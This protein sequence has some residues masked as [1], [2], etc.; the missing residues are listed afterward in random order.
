MSSRASTARLIRKATVLGAIYFATAWLGLRFSPV[1]GFATLIWPPTGIALAAL[2]LYGPRLWPGIFLAATAVNFLTGAPLHVAVAIGVG[3]TLGPLA[4]ARMLV[5]ARF[6]PALDRLKDIFALTVFAASVSTAISATIGTLSLTAGGIAGFEA[7]VS[8]WRAW[9]IGDML[10]VLIFAPLILTWLKPTSEPGFRFVRLLERIALLAIF[11]TSSWLVFGGV[12]ADPAAA[13]S[14][15][16][17]FAP[18]VIWAALRFSPRETATGVFIISVVAIWGTVTGH[19]PFVR[20]SIS[21]SLF[22]LQVFMGV[23]AVSGMVVAINAEERRRVEEELKQSNHELTREARRLS[24]EKGRTEALLASLGEGVIAVD[25]RGR[26]VAMNPAAERMFEVDFRG[27]RGRH[28]SEAIVLQDEKGRPIPEDERP[29]T[30]SLKT[31]KTNSTSLAAALYFT[32]KDGSRLP[33]AVTSTVVKAGSDL[34][35]GVDVFRDISKEKEIDRAKTEFVSLASHQL[36]TPLTTAKWYLELLQSD[37]NGFSSGQKTNLEEVRRSFQRMSELVNDLLSVSRIERGVF[38]AVQARVD[39]VELTKKVI[40]DY[41]LQLEEKGITLEETYDGPPE[42][43]IADPQLLHI[44]LE[45]LV[46]NGIK[47]SSSRGTLTIVLSR[48]RTGEEVG[49]RKV[50]KDSLLIAVAD[51]G[52]GIPKHQ[53]DQIFTKFFRAKNVL[54]REVEGTG[55]G[56]YITKA[57]VEKFG[58]E[59]WFES[60]EGKGTTFFV[61]LPSA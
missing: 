38:S 28:V 23:V 45:D 51:T 40:E 30:I 46:S 6:R 52:W 50:R 25:R 43:V 39:P 59:I 14:F 7:F 47:Y 31:G 10:G 41:R 3:N 29:I 57:I 49:G 37:G 15:I 33:I 17:V 16:Y 5:W 34:L 27:I 32:R 22:Y 56:L 36:R 48:K 19:G 60:E 2:A 61:L 35:G 18:P 53:Q 9:W 21:E 44:A 20:A 8:T 54:D 55:L 12:L 42:A 13:A 4:A 58:G 26:V 24:E 11:A 1:S